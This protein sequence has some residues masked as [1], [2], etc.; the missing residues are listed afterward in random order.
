MYHRIHSQTP[1]YI[2]VF[3]LIYKI[4]SRVFL[5]RCVRG[6]ACQLGH[7]EGARAHSEAH[8]F[9]P[10][11]PAVATSTVNVSVRAVIQIRRIQRTMTLAAAEAPLVPH[12]VL[13]DHLLGGVHRVAATRATVSVVSLLPELGLGVD[14]TK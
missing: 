1:L 11:V 14:A 9:G 12:A 13:R 4:G 2:D 6:K 7:R 8:A 5:E 10:K 3:T